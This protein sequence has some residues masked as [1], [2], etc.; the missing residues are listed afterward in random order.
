LGYLPGANKH[1]ILIDKFYHVIAAVVMPIESIS[2]FS[3]ISKGYSSPSI[4]EIRPSAGGVYTGLQA[5]YGWN[6]ELGVKMSAL[7][8]KLYFTATVFQFDLRDAIVRRVN[9]AG[10]E[11]FMNQ[12]DV[13]AKG[14]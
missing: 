1:W 6:K 7:R 2:F 5:E 8:N 14:N 3:Q 4:A 9:S 11:Y 10:A 13:K 12:G